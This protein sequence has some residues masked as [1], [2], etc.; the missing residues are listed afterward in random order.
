MRIS[1]RSWG[2]S[3]RPVRSR[4]LAFG[5]AGQPAHA[6]L[7]SVGVTHRVPGTGRGVSVSMDFGWGGPVARQIAV[8][9][10]RIWF[11]TRVE[12]CKKAG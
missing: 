1:I 11:G 3:A 12:S 8:A 6:G 2:G 10:G 5:E 7:D 9:R 4:T